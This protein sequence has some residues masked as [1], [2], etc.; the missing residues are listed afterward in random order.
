MAIYVEG[1]SALVHYRSEYA[2]LDSERC[3]RNVLEM[4]EATSSRAQIEPLP[5]WRLGIGEPSKQ[6]PLRVLVPNAKLNCRSDVVHARIWSTGISGKAFRQVAAQIYVSSP[7]FVFLQMAPSLSLPEL[8]ALGME[9]CGTYRRQVRTFLPGDDEPSF[10][11]EYHQPILTTPKRIAGFLQS[12]TSAPGCA[13]A[14]KALEYVL[15]NS[16]SPMETTLYLLLCLPRR[17]G[18]YALPKPALNPP[19]K[20]TKAGKTYTIRNSAKPDLYWAKVRLDLE[21]NSDEFHTESQRALDSMRRKALEEMGVEVIELTYEEVKNESLLHATA[22]RIARRFKRRIR[23]EWEGDFRQRRTN[24]RDLIFPDTVTE[25]ASTH[26]DD[27]E[28]EPD[29]IQQEWPDEIWSDETWFDDASFDYESLSEESMA[30][31]FG[32]IDSQDDESHV[33]GARPWKE[34][35]G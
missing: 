4:Q 19:I 26:E 35:E 8:V 1:T 15:P 14:K 11:T 9:L 30:E 32:D 25:S 3:S 5:Y 16:A 12:M 33:F 2:C 10:I 17:L 20:F 6:E 7:E 21:Y 13:K 31:E 22:R 23:A 27:Q 18:G 34:D 29:W 24:L 28:V